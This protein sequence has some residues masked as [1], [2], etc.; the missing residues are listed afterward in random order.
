MKTGSMTNIQRTSLLM[1]I[2]I[3]LLFAAGGILFQWPKIEPKLNEW[4]KVSEEAGKPVALGGAD[5]FQKDQLLPSLVTDLH[6][7]YTINAELDPGQAVI[8][9]TVNVEFDN[10]KTKDLY[11]YVYGYTWK[12]IQIKGIWHGK[13]ALT[14]QRRD[15]VIV[16]NN[17]DSKSKRLTLAIQFETPVP[18]SPTRFGVA[19]DIWTLT[20]WYPMLGGL[21]PQKKWYDPPK[22][23]GY[24]DPF[25]FHY[26]DYDVMFTSPGNYQWVTSSGPGEQTKL[27]DGRKQ[28]HIRGKKLLNFALL[29]SPSYKVETIKVNGL[30]VD[31]ASTQAANINRIKTIV[32]EVLPV[33]T[34][35]YGELPYPRV[36]IAETGRHAV[37]AMEYPNLAIFS[38]DM[39]DG[40]RVDHWLPHEIAHL[41]WYNSIAT[42]ESTHGWLDEGLVELSV[43]HYKKQR[44]GEQ[45]A[46]QE[47]NEYKEDYQFL[48]NKYPYGKLAKQLTQL[49]SDEFNWTWYSTGALLYN[50]LREQLGDES[51]RAF[52]QNVQ[53]NYHGMVIG[54]K[55]LDQA[56]GHVLRAKVSYFVPNVQKLNQEPFVPMRVEY[57][58]VNIE[59]N[60]MSYYPIVPARKIGNTVYLP[61]RE[62]MER[63]GYRVAYTR[64]KGGINLKAGG[65]DVLL[66]AKT[67]KGK[68][69]DKPFTLKQP[70]IEVQERAMVPLAFFS[71]VMKYQV[72]YDD[73]QRIAKITVTAK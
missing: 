46:Q 45:V 15:P 11:V 36:G 32:Q 63:L 14:Y 53:R 55:H 20:T 62:V 30:T 52:L 68:L 2:A 67:N 49:N 48:Q 22:P 7:A 16:L 23:I 51:Y 35:W 10:P 9:G 8:K 28:M 72:R 54:P 38:R 17:P 50:N 57:Y 5:P 18:R 25:V 3:L 19:D 66:Y 44:Y 4:L 69:N 65:N 43:Y 31:I 1:C 24:G 41:W 61:L 70:L 37:Y 34:K 39:Y 73:E 64:E 21:S 27:A 13:Q 60:G 33:Y 6:P 59:I 26:G 42:L 58:Q 40:N 47:L 12:P 29:G 56:L 71:D